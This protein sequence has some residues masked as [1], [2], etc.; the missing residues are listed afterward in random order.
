MLIAISTLS[1]LALIFGAILGYSAKRFKVEGDPIIDKIDELLPQTQCG[2]CTYAG[3]KPYAT[4]ISEGKAEIN[5]CPP[6][7]EE[8]MISIADLLGVDEVPLSEETL[9]DNEKLVAI[10]NEET[11]IGCT[12]CIKKCPVDAIVGASK[13]MHTVI[14][15]E[16]TGCKL[17]VDPC[18]VVDCIQ[19]VPLHKDIKQWSWSLPTNGT[20][21]SH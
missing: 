8:T 21:E 5:L 12:L 18:P 7:G 11:C 19:M 2:Q 14:E 3:C 10:I 1:I 15:S 4:A 13:L 20:K 9:A 6:G 16:C 17:C